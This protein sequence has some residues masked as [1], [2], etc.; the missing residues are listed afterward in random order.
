MIK[1]IRKIKKTLEFKISQIISTKVKYG[2]I[3]GKRIYGNLYLN[4]RLDTLSDE[5]IFYKYLNLEDKVVVELG[6]NL[7][8]YTIYFS[9]ATG[10]G[11][12][13]YS[14]EP[15]PI[16]FNLLEKNIKINNCDNV[17]LFNFGVGESDNKLIFISKQFVFETGSF[18]KSIQEKLKKDKFGYKTWDI[19]VKK[20]D[21]VKDSDIKEKV[22]FMKIDIEGMEMEA[23]IGAKNLIQNDSP[24]I[25]MEIHGKD[26]EIKIEKLKII[27]DYLRELNINYNGIHLPDCINVNEIISSKVD[28]E[29]NHRN[30]L[31]TYDNYAFFFSTNN[32]FD[33]MKQYFGD[34]KYWRIK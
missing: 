28:I 5:E 7:G 13:V 25:Y 34:K 24:D 3:T 17:K 14:F 31:Y 15:N 6:A 29:F 2:L 22:D 23:L 21:T 10:K 18:D 33:L 20:L 32:T 16:I 8:V 9:T 1:K 27:A 19:N 11:G 30:Q 12:K 4:V 26:N